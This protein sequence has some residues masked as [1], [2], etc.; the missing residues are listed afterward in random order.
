MNARVFAALSLI[1]ILLLSAPFKV[2]SQDQEKTFC[3]LHDF[4]A[5]KSKD[6][7]WPLGPAAMALAD[8]GSIWTTINRG[9][10]FDVGAVIKITPDGKYTKVTD[11]DQLSGIH[12]EGGLVNGNNGYLF[13]TTSEGGRWGAGTIF[14]IR[15]QGGSLEV[16]YDFRNGRTTG[17]KPKGE[18][19]TRQNCK[20]SPEQKANMSGGRPVSAPVVVGNNLYG[21]TPVSNNQFYGTLYSIPLNTGPATTNGDDN[22]PMKV[23]C[24]F[25]PSLAKD[26]EMK[27]FRCNTNGTNARFLIAGS[28]GN[29][30]GTTYATDAGPNGTVFRASPQGGSVSFLYE[31][32][33]KD[34][35]MPVALMEASDGN[36]YGTALKGGSAGT[37]VVFKIHPTTHQF[38]V[39]TNFPKP[40][41]N[42]YTPGVTP[43]SGIVEGDDGNLYGTLQGGGL[44][45]GG[46]LYRVSKEKNDEGDYNFRVLRDFDDSSGGRK[47]VALANFGDGFIYGTAFQ[48]GAFGGGT[49]YRYKID[50]VAIGGGARKVYDDLIEVSEQSMATQKKGFFQ[51]TE[52][53]LP[54][55]GISVR[56]KCDN[57]PHFVQFIYREV[58]QLNQ[59]AIAPGWENQ[60]NGKLL[61]TPPNNPQ[62]WSFHRSCDRCSSYTGTSDLRDLHW[63]PD[64]PD[65][66]GMLSGLFDPGSSYFEAGHSAELDCDSLTLFDRPELPAS[67]F[68]APDIV[69]RTVARDYALCGGQ[70]VEQVTWISDETVDQN[71][72]AHWKYQA[73]L[74]KITNKKIPDFFLCLLKTNGYPLPAGQSIS[75][76]LDCDHPGLATV[77]KP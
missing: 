54:D 38:E 50:R 51:W 2:T 69:V 60:P 39:V 62:P 7:V 41:D 10:A 36:L 59:I 61:A 18:C 68:F 43:V 1:F 57:D 65:A 23:R 17:V 55:H 49:F 22:E 27:Q 75:S 28:N 67:F 30:Y 33:G 24:I 74:N 77:G 5:P 31:F 14:R 6:A 25:Q 12:P 26:P 3:V 52:K 44:Y 20:Y 76:G 11:F 8:D 63:A 34:G 32:D 35:R 19:T 46:I 29:L 45:G 16:L 64:A 70:V 15:V 13:G 42:T 71:K 21:V 9:G 4:G 40:A 66:P 37:D 58:I 56:L 48:G 53:K 73:K 47:P 72:T